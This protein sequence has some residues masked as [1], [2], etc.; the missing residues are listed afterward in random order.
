MDVTEFDMLIGK[1]LES[2]EHLR[3]GIGGDYELENSECIEFKFTDNTL[4]QMWHQRCC[5]EDVYVED[6][7]G[8]LA[9]LVGEP[10]LQFEEASRSSLIG[11]HDGCSDSQ[12]W[13]FYKMATIKGAVTIRW[14]GSS[15]GYYGESA[16]LRLTT[17][18]GS[19]KEYAGAGFGWYDGN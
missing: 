11:E 1:T 16:D 10:L 15:N 9:D 3:P 14:Y 4:L 8:D 13:T 6:I 12:T 17:P 2:V 7:C 19:V 18:E 5:C